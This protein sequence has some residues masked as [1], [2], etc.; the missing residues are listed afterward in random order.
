VAEDVRASEAVA[1]DQPKTSGTSRPVSRAERARRG[2]YRY[3]FAAIYFVLAAVVGAGVGSFVVLAT[4]DDPP[5]EAAWST[6]VPEGSPTAKTRQIADYVSRRYR[7]EDHQQLVKAIASKPQV[8]A[9]NPP[10]QIPVPLIAVRPDTSRGQAEEDDIELYQA[11]AAVS[12]QLCGFDPNRCAITSGTPSQER[13]LL[14]RRQA[15]ELSLYTFKYVDDIDSVLVFLPPPAN[16]AEAQ[17]S[18]VFLRRDD[19]R[20]ELKSPLLRTLPD[21]EVPAIGKIMPTEVNAIERITGSRLYTH[22][23]TLLQAE[24]SPVIVLTP[25]V[26]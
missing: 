4:Q 7:G 6:F 11:N 18:S 23:Y 22:E 3:R 20:A 1:V 21:K 15:L 5:P 24:Q 8:T 25:I 12:Y 16:D 19:V 10:Q 9:G 17:V 14:L 13:H 26:N 2:G